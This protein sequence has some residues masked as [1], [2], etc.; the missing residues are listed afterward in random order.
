MNK[1]TLKG[2]VVG[3]VMASLIVGSATATVNQYLLTPASYPVI[4]DG[5]NLDSEDYP[6]LNYNGTTYL[7]LRKTAEAVN[8]NLEWNDE[9][10]QAELNTKTQKTNT[11]TESKTEVEKGDNVKKE[12]F[13]EF[14]EN[15]NIYLEEVNGEQYMSIGAFS[16]YVIKEEDNYYIKL[17]NQNAIHVK[18]GTEPTEHSITNVYK[19]TLVKLSSLNLTAEV[20]GD[21]ITVYYK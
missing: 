2:F 18:S 19:R 15:T 13:G 21:T 12:V 20:N 6:I 9:L 11:I 5:V 1:N 10:K 8:A 17:P 14:K 16:A 4:A 3:F 7:S